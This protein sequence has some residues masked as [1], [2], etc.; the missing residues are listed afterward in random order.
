MRKRITKASLKNLKSY[1]VLSQRSAVPSI[2][3]RRKLSLTSDTAKKSKGKLSKEEKMRMLK[4]GRRKKGLV[5]TE[6]VQVNVRDAT[7]EE[8]YEMWDGSGNVQLDKSSVK[9]S[10]SLPPSSMLMHDSIATIFS[11]PTHPHPILFP[12]ISSKINPNST[13]RNVLQ[14]HICF[15]PIA[16]PRSSR[17]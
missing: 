1:Q 6:T 12:F 2:T 9:V 8:K 7:G 5:D 3:S 14:P 16:P 10:P 13:R 11:P 4:L 15:T 17:S